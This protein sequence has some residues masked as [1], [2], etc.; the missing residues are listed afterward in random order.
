MPKYVLINADSAC[1]IYDPLNRKTVPPGALTA[2]DSDCEKYFANAGKYIFAES[3]GVAELQNISNELA[4]A[5][6]EKLAAIYKVAQTAYS[7][8]SSST[9][10][11]S[12]S[13]QVNVL[14][15]LVYG[16]T[17]ITELSKVEIIIS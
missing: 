12:I 1:I 10:I 2:T 11:A 13:V 5:Q 8:A 15:S 9:D 7:S 16:C 3:S 4:S 17:T 6:A 14:K